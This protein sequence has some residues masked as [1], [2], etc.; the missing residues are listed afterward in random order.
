MGEKNKCESEKIIVFLPDI[1]YIYQLFSEHDYN[2]KLC[3]IFKSVCRK[4]DSFEIISIVFE[5]L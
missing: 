1:I 4:T 5:V 2:R 3:A